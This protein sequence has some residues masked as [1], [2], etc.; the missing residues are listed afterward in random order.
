MD[1]LGGQE[2][3][4]RCRNTISAALAAADLE[5]DEAAVMRELEAD[6]EALQSAD[7]WR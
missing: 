6:L 2:R 5:S 4:I 7:D 1:E 3:L